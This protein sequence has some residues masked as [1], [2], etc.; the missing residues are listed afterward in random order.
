MDGN[1]RFA[2]QLG[3]PVLFGHAKGVATATKVLEWWLEHPAHTSPPLPRYLTCWAFSSENFGRRA[4][5]RDGLFA[6]MTAEFNSLAFTSFVHLL[7]IRVSFIGGDRHRFPP[8]LLQTMALIAVG[9][10]GRE[11]IVSTACRLVGR[12]ADITEEGILRKTYC[13]QRGIPPV[14][15]II[16]TSER[17][18]FL[19]DMQ[20]AELHFLTEL[21]WLHA[22]R[23]F[24]KREIRGGE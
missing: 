23:N 16:R 22:I 18:F 14:N 7:C 6:L 21:D 2:R 4:D 8:E 20:T 12:G 10:G 11:E 5:E 17:R 1:R 9:Y 19:W 24:S 15:L 3:Q 13:Y